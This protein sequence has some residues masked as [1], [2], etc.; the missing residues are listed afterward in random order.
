MKKGIL[1]II[2]IYR[3]KTILWPKNIKKNY[4]IRLKIWKTVQNFLFQF[5]K[6]DNE[7]LKNTRPVICVSSNN[8]N[9]QFDINGFSVKHF[10]KLEYWIFDVFFFC[11]EFL[12]KNRWLIFSSSMLSVHNL[13][14][15]WFFFITFFFC[16]YELRQSINFCKKI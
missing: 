2:G 16:R 12:V 3:F 4:G 11:C 6:I 10:W 15:S 14:F 13:H 1:W 7:V 8:L 5:L 9:M